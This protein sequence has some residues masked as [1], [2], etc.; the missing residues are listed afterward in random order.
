MFKKFLSL[1]IITSIF[2]FMKQKKID[3]NLLNNLK[4]TNEKE[5]KNDNL[6]EW[7]KKLIIEIPNDIIKNETKGYLEDLTLY[8]ISL[9]RIITTKPS[10]I[11][12]KMGVI[13]SIE[14]TAI[15]INGIFNSF[16]T[17]SK[18]FS[19]HISNLNVKLPFFLVSDPVT[20]LVTEVDTSGFNID[21][22]S[23][24]IEVEIDIIL[25]D[26]LIGILKLVLKLIK[27][28]VIE[29]KLIET[30]NKQFEEL[31]QKANNVIINGV[32]P[33]ELNT[34]IKESDLADLKRSPI[35]STVGY[36]LSNLTGAN[37]P[38]A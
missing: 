17:G 28:S 8:E 12:G 16:I 19:A 3:S 38:L 21:L 33:K 18:V 10:I 15:S 24:K 9:E 37:G 31:F 25:K 6:R 5:T 35:I 13:I 34:T 2:C 7:L 22:D 36:L 30:M 4:M 14:E 23:A 27:T 1:I 29:K 11:D 32:E 20:G 26:L